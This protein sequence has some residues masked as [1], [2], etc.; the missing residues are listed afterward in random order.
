LKR[1]T[2]HVPKHVRHRSALESARQELATSRLE[3]YKIFLLGMMAGLR[4]NEIDVLPWTASLERGHDPHRNNRVLSPEVAHSEGDVR[5][6]RANGAFRG[7]FARR[8][9]DFVI[10]GDSPPPPFDAPYGVYRCQNHMRALLSWLRTKVLFPER[11][12]AR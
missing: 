4:R 5:W 1:Y 8:K 10:Q 7:F 6:I 11:H 2:Y 3:Q 12:C 9:S